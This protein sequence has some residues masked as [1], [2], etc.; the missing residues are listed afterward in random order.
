MRIVEILGGIRLPVNEEEKTFLKNLREKGSLIFSKLDE[1]NL[2]IAEN[3]S[4]RNIVNIKEDKI[5]FNN[6]ER[7]EFW[8]W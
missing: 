1:R 7:M 3:L 8:K 4:R 2:M 6:T 5:T